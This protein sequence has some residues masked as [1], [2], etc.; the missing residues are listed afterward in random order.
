MLQRKQNLCTTN[1]VHVTSNL[2]KITEKAF[3]I[4]HFH[5]V[6]LLKFPRKCQVLDMMLDLP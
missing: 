6:F 3:P 4:T 1:Y 2:N 5:G